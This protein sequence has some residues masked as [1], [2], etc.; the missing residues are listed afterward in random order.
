MTL[1]WDSKARRYRGQGGRFVKREAVSDALEKARAEGRKRVSQLTQDLKDGRINLAQWSISMRDE[2]KAQHLLHAGIAKGGKAQLSPADLGRIGQ[3]TRVQ[4]ERL[5]AYARQIEQGLNP[6][7]GRSQLYVN[8]SY[9]TFTETEK[10]L[11]ASAG[12]ERVEWVVNGDKESCAGCV[13][14][15]GVYPIDDVPE[16]GSHE[17]LV[18]CRCELRY[19]RA[20]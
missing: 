10:R 20:A 19:L 15:A 8:A 2:I 4:Y 1:T 7:I 11:Q 9:S 12:I 3:L 5:N 6:N 16:I 13:G 14:A 18:N 17:C